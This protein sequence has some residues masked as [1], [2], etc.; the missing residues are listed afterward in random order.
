MIRGVDEW[1]A[2]DEE[3]FARSVFRRRWL[4]ALHRS[5]VT[6]VGQ[7][8]AMSA[9]QLLRIPNVG[10]KAIAEISQALGDVT[11]RGDDPLECLGLP[12]ARVISERDRELIRMR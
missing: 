3:V 1:S 5:R 8:R 12:T 2:L 11:V 4:N 10:A 7:A 9:D 6:T